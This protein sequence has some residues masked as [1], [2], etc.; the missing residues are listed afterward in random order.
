MISKIILFVIIS[1]LAGVIFYLIG[2][3]VDLQGRV[4]GIEDE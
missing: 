2:E 4:W 1:V 3:V